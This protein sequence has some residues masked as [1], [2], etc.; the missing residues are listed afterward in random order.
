M[1]FSQFQT[2]LI[3][4]SKPPLTSGGIPALTVPGTQD[5]VGCWV[6]DRLDQANEEANGNDMVRGGGPV[7]D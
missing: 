5:V 7:F 1:L 6:E 2:V 4:V 3:A